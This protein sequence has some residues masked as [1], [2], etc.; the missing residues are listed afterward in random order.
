MD[1]DRRRFWRVLLLI[2]LVA[3]AVRVTYVFVEKRDGALTGDELFY[4][5][6]ANYLADGNLFTEP[7]NPRFGEKGQGLLGTGPAAD[8]PP[9]TVSFLTPISFVSD[10]SELAQRL[11]MTVV[12]FGTVLAIG[13]LAFDLAGKRAG[14]IAAGIA[15]VYPNLFVND[16]LVMS[17]SLSAL[18]VTLTLLFGYRLLRAPSLRL[19]LLVG[20][21][22]GLAALTRAEL[23]LLVPLLAVPAALRA[24]SIALRERWKLVGAGVAATVLLLLPWV[25]YN[26]ARF[27]EPTFIS[28]NDGSALIGSNCED[29][30]Y[31]DG[32]GLWAFTCLGE[33]PR[34][35]QSVDSRIWRDRAFDYIRDHTE[36]V[37]A[38][39]L[40]RVGRTWSVFR[41]WDMVD[42]NVFEGRE[43]WV[44]ISGL[45]LFYPLVV[46][47]I[48][49]GVVLWRRK[50]TLWPLLVP[51]VI[52][53]L[54]S[55]A[56]YGQTRFR[57]PAEPS[58]IVLA[59]IALAAL[60]A[61]A[62]AGRD[63]P[64]PAPLPQPR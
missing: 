28:T 42:Y 10:R 50:A 46:A 15:A 62:N 47:T 57:V 2:A 40:A 16:G 3:L 21:L 53:T 24:T 32:T 55:A 18:L 48:A 30:Y 5:A 33:S 64:R 26:L 19:A 38:V 29:V 44:T 9:L 4:N 41:P 13:V 63:R 61:R 35:D 14:W 8:H 51:P 34:G 49:G 12:G 59:A 56:T 7:F 39:V 43:E 11:M 20:G 45:F 27:D 60:W 31:G 6:E 23:L 25:G 22:C 58:L 36:R 54:V 17:E 52:V 37:P 1:A